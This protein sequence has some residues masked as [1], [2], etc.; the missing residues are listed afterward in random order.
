L[1]V[2]DLG[3]DPASVGSAGARQQVLSV[4]EAEARLA[5]ELVVDEGDAHERV[6]AF[7][8]QLKVL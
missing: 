3:L 5:G 6:I 8:E 7:L 1:T 2:A 4:E